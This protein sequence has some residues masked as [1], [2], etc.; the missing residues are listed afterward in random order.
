M[1]MLSQVNTVADMKI[2]FPS[3]INTE[4]NQIVK[5]FVDT[6]KGDGQ[7]IENYEKNRR[8]TYAYENNILGK[9][10][11]FFA[12]EALA[13]LFGF[14]NIDIDLEVREGR[15]KGW[16][17]DL[18]YTSKYDTIPNVH[19]KTCDDFTVRYA[20]P[21]WTFQLKNANGFGG[22][23]P[24]LEKGLPT[25]L[26]AFVYLPS[27]ESEFAIVHAIVPWGAITKYPLL[28]MPVKANLKD[29]KRCVYLSDL[30]MYKKYI[31]KWKI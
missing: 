14:P 1:E 25:D 28:Q 5:V 10:G 26:V 18:P 4:I 13:T 21:S 29:I 2:T 24:I 20:G 19:V 8:A 3:D 31:E 23:D 6:Q 7:A 22:T 11:E 27:W 30:Q 16:M 9:K 17:P 12:H 15:S